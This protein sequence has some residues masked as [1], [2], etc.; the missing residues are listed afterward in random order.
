ML[1]D[2]K[3][4]NPIEGIITLTYGACLEVLIIMNF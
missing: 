3:F 1:I 2:W 4:H